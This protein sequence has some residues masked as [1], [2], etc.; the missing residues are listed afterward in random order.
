MI[1]TKLYTILTII[2]RISAMDTEI[3]E[4]QS[5]LVYIPKNYNIFANG[6]N[7][8][9]LWADGVNTSTLQNKKVIV[10]AQNK[11]LNLTGTNL[12]QEISCNYEFSPVVGA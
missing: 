1:S 9:V 8:Q 5:D 2:V 11:K 4:E 12:C 6:L 7:M 10:Q 3:K